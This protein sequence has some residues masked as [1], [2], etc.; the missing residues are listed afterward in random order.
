MLTTPGIRRLTFPVL[1]G[2]MT[3]Q[4]CDGRTLAQQT[5]EQPQLTAETGNLG[6]DRTARPVSPPVKDETSVKKHS[7]TPLFVGLGFLGLGVVAI[8]VYTWL[9]GMGTELRNRD[10]ELGSDY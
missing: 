3:A 4:G 2:M 8:G 6:F 5:A 1:V 7:N 9:W 10:T